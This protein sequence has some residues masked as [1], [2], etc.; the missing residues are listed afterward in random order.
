MF[1]AGEKNYFDSVK[2]IIEKCSGKEKRP[3]KECTETI[4]C[5]KNEKLKS[6]PYRE[7]AENFERYEK[8]KVIEESADYYFYKYLKSLGKQDE[9]SFPLEDG[10]MVTAEVDLFSPYEEIYN[11]EKMIKPQWHL[12]VA[13]YAYLDVAYN[14]VDSQI[15][16]Y[17]T[18]KQKQLIKDWS[19]NNTIS[20]WM[21][22]A[23]IDK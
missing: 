14:H 18:W 2:D 21:K 1:K 6:N 3:L 9:Y 15:L 5:Y 17:T 22:E 16:E 4:K 20:M 19:R 10:C 8:N 11:Q 23:R 7:V 12:L 13:Y